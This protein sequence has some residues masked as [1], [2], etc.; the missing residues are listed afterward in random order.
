[1]SPTTSYGSSSP[2]S[3][4]IVWRGIL[5]LLVAVAIICPRWAITWIQTGAHIIGSLMADHLYAVTAAI[6]Q[7]AAR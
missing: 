5:Y 3:A 2:S 7:A 6:E 4:F 1:M